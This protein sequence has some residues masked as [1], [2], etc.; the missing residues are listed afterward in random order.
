MAE[1]VA[2]DWV[3]K[4]PGRRRALLSIEQ[5]LI[6]G[7]CG[8]HT[9]PAWMSNYRNGYSKENSVSKP[10]GTSQRPSFCIFSVGSTRLDG[11]LSKGCL[12]SPC[13]APGMLKCPP[14]KPR[15]KSVSDVFPV[16]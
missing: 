8:A 14:H 1:F 7:L 13:G 2:I 11:L 15:A 10:T 6:S 16:H 9:F 3:A 5:L 12:V 4:G